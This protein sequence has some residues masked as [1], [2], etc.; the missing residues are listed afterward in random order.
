MNRLCH[1]DWVK[2]SV[3]LNSAPKQNMRFSS[4][5]QRRYYSRVP[6]PIGRIFALVCQW[7]TKTEKSW[8]ER[9]N[10]Q[11]HLQEHLSP[12]GFGC[13]I[14]RLHLCGKKSSPTSVF[15]MTLNNPMVRLQKWWGFR[16]C[17]VPLHC[18]CSQIHSGQK[19]WPLIESYV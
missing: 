19:R 14:H 5:L 18:H 7:Y 1:P 6:T 13:R 10:K 15:D 8:K 3:E 4:S 11:L 16:E 12:V 9:Q 2:F 17:G